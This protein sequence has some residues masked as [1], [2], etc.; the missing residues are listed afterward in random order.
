MYLLYIFPL[1]SIHLWLRCSHFFNLTKKN[2]FV[3]SANKKKENRKSQRLISTFTYTNFQSSAWK[4]KNKEVPCG[5]PNKCSL[6]YYFQ[7]H[8]TMV[9]KIH[10][11]S[12]LKIYLNYFLKF[13]SYLTEKKWLQRHCTY[14]LIYD[15]PWV[16]SLDIKSVFSVEHCLLQ[17]TEQQWV[18]SSRLNRF[19][20]IY[21]S[22]LGP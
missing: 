19:R 11:V 4:L 6:L 5:F 10:L 22:L 9:V 8:V 7:E 12:K 18:L 17:N 2:S 16:F 20:R 3:C 21:I 14:F 15:R 1:S 13:N